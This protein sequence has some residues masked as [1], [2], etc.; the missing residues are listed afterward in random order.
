MFTLKFRHSFGKLRRRGLEAV[1]A[2]Q[3]EKV[4]AY[5]FIHMIRK[6]KASLKKAA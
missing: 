3:M 1:H 4:I 6:E 2:E 5:N